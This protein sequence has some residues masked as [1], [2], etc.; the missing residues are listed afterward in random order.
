MLDLK[1]KPCHLGKSM[2]INTEHHGDD[3][4]GAIDI[5]ID[6]IM[7]TAKELDVLLG[8]GAHA[9]LFVKPKGRGG[10][11]AM[12]EVRFL[13]FLPLGFKQKFEKA[14]VTL[15]VGM[16]PAKLVFADC[17]IGSVRL[18]PQTG[19]LTAMSCSVRARP[20]TD[21]VGTL[22]E[23]RNTTATLWISGAERVEDKNDKQGNLGLG[24]NGEDDEGEDDD[25]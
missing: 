12:P 22:F 3:D 17:K 23:G 6:G 13:H 14:K 10:A 7:L 19:G 16:A 15:H 9:A 4:V 1:Q 11:D 25:E 2:S 18:T 8:D 21:D 5:P 20:E 24:E